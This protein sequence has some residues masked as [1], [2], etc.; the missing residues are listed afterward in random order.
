MINVLLLYPLYNLADDAHF[1]AVDRVTE[2][3]IEAEGDIASKLLHD[4]G[5][6]LHPWFGNVGIMITATEK[7]GRSFQ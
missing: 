4:L 7:D 6:K 1:V 3:G 5:G 2:V